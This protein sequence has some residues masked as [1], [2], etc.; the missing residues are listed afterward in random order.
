MQISAYEMLG[1][2]ASMPYNA[3]PS[4]R[5]VPCALT[6]QLG[7]QYMPSQVESRTKHV[8]AP[9]SPLLYGILR[10]KFFGDGIVQA[11]SGQRPDRQLAGVATCIHVAFVKPGTR[12]LDLA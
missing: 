11:A 5:Q 2:Y 1:E 7:A 12:T 8:L 6:V 10:A 4:S 3:P 9:L